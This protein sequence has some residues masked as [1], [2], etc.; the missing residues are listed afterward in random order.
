MNKIVIISFL[1]LTIVIFI[2]FIVYFFIL[3]KQGNTEIEKA[4]TTVSSEKEIDKSPKDAECSI[5]NGTTKEGIEN[6]NDDSNYIFNVMKLGK[7]IKYDISSTIKQ[8]IRTMKK[9]SKI[10]ETFTFSTSIVPSKELLENDSYYVLGTLDPLKQVTTKTSSLNGG[11]NCLSFPTNV[12]KLIPPCSADKTRDNRGV[13]VCRPE[14]SFQLNNGTC[15]A[16]LTCSSDK[17]QSKDT[18]SCVCRPELSFQLNNGTCIAPLT[19]SSDKIQSKDTGSCVCR[20]GLSFQLNNG[21]CIAPLTCSS[22]KIQSKD[23]GSCI[24]RPGLSFQL[25]NGTCIAPLTCPKNQLQSRDIGTCVCP[26][27]LSFKLNDDTCI[28]PL[29]CPSDQIQSRDTGACQC[30][31][32]PIYETYI[33]KDIP[34]NDLRCFRNPS[35]PWPGWAEDCRIECDKDPNCKAYNIVNR[36]G[37]WGNDWGCCLKNATSA[38][39]NPSN[40]IDYYRKVEGKMIIGS[41][42]KCTI[43][44]STGETRDSNEICQ[45]SSGLTRINGVCQC[46]GG[47]SLVNGVCQCP[48]GQSLVNGVCQC[49]GGQILV[50]GV[51]QCPGGQSLVNGVCQCPWGQSLVNGV[52]KCRTGFKIG[53][54]GTCEIDLATFSVGGGGF[55]NVGY[56]G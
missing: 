20:P 24:C 34:S 23:T 44:C 30:M 42:S 37:A 50:N 43:P 26:S 47:Q 16:P 15:V 51:C 46:P 49:P 29:T 33:G 10:N 25:N 45:C 41:N 22:D 54:D 52:C 8:F 48:G 6:A 55:G 3:K 32:K 17:I 9:K 36:Y 7:D 13:C 35:K 39:V 4:D 12:Y 27:T 14:L 18:G 56:W 21:T 2:L 53:Y 19:C 31:Q 1:I 38:P 40:K 28:A 5:P 11:A